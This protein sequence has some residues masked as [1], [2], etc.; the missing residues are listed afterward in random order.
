MHTFCISAFG[1][2]S[3]RGRKDKIVGEK[4]GG[5]EIWI[6]KKQGWKGGNLYEGATAAQ[7]NKQTSQYLVI[8]LLTVSD[9]SITMIS[10]YFISRRY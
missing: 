4:E 10:F 7:S 5:I 1:V 9:E 3:G 8:H 2:D 6:G